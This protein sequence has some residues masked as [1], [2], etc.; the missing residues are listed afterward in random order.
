[1]VGDEYDERRIYS[2]KIL[3]GASPDAP[4][5][6]GSAG[7]LPSRKTRYSLFAAVFSSAVTSSSNFVHRL[8]SVAAVMKPAKAG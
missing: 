8:K 3:E 7:A 4:K 6:F 1:V 5:I 2:A